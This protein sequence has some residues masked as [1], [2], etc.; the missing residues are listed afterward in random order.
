MDV[1][2]LF[3]GQKLTVECPNCQHKITIDASLVFKNNSKIHCSDCDNDI[4]LDNSKT[5]RDIEKA[6]KGF[7]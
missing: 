2:K 1:S 5:K 7:K 3:K 4:S 6:I